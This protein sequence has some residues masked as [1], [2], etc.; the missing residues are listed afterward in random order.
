MRTERYAVRLYAIAV[1]SLLALCIPFSAHNTLLADIADES[2]IGVVD[3]AHNHD[4]DDVI[5]TKQLQLPPGYDPEWSDFFDAAVNPV[6][7]YTEGLAREATRPSSWRCAANDT[8]PIGERTVFA[9]VHVYKAAGSTVRSFFH[10][11][12]YACHRTWA[13]LA[14]CTKVLPS[15]IRSRGPWEPCEMEEVADG[16]SRRKAQNVS[17][18]RKY[19]AR[20]R[21]MSNPSLERLVDIYGGHAR[22]GTADYAFPASPRGSHVRY[23]TFMRN[24]LERF[25]SGA[26]YQ[27]IVWKRNE[28]LETVVKKIK[29]HVASERDNDRYFS[30]SLSYLLTPVQREV[31]DRIDFKQFRLLVSNE[32][33]IAPDS[34]MSA[35]KAE[36]RFRVA[37]RNLFRYN[38]IVG[39]SERMAESLSIL[40]HVFLHQAPDSSSKKEA[41]RVF[42]KFGPATTPIGNSSNLGAMGG[43]RANKSARDGVSTEIVVAELLKDEGFVALFNEHAKYERMITDFAWNMHRLQ[44]DSVVGASQ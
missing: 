31:N 36:V 4:G 42:K 7:V 43:V 28:T 11:L 25:V 22:I 37:I 14:T 21:P 30:K 40:R 44:Y 18:R 29:R 12:A 5:A 38:V 8:D 24:P 35:F 6:P 26:L 17:P 15:S 27:N 1:L 9:F 19:Y 3:A 13:S 34:S 41:E 20:P 23:I 10:Q 39:M 16:R 33:L 32:T 2:A